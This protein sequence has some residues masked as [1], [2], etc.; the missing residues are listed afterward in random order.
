MNNQKKNN[1]KKFRFQ[2]LDKQLELWCR[3]LPPY[4]IV[5][6]EVD[7]QLPD[8][9]SDDEKKRREEHTVKSLCWLAKTI[10]RYIANIKSGRRYRSRVI[11]LLTII[12]EEVERGL[13]VTINN[14]AAS[15]EEK[16]IDVDEVISR[17][18]MRGVKVWSKPDEDVLKEIDRIIR[19]QLLEKIMLFLK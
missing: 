1:D 4:Q 12:H 11:E 15:F 3:D 8:S 10:N 17:L 19:H 2:Q 13:D 9:L 6:A 18:E 7:K 5:M 14:Y 16:F